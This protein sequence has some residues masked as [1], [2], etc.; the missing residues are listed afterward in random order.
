MFKNYE[1]GFQL[2]LLQVNYV[3]IVKNLKVTND[4]IAEK[5]WS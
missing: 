3:L 5:E 2:I 4:A 1:N